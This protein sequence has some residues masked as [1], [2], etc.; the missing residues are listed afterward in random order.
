MAEETWRVVADG[1]EISSIGNVKA[2]DK[3]HGLR[4]PY[5]PSASRNGYVSF[6]HNKKRY[7]LARE[8]LT[9]F[10]GPAPVGTTVD[11][12]NGIRNDNRVCNLRW[13]TRSEQRLNQVGRR[14]RNDRDP[15]A[16]QDNLP[17]EDWVQVGRYNVS[18]MGRAQVMRSHG[19]AWGHVFTPKPSSKNVYAEIGR[20]NAFHR[21]V[22][23]A[24]LGP[25]PDK[26]YTV[27]HIDRDPT[28][29]ALDNLRWANKHTQSLNQQP[30]RPL[31]AL[32]KRVEVFDTKCNKWITFNSF[33]EAARDLE[34]AFPGKTFSSAGVGLTAR[35]LGTYHGVRL[36]LPG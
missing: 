10:V 11:H 25:P 22:A 20:G 15:D 12:I 7:Y 26:T 6:Q 23:L 3:V 8:I 32:S 5:K 1:L 2:L 9:A 16:N 33:T 29:N 35:R 30:G 21:V 18:N 14:N 36:R 27:D 34:E 24:F 28:N 31:K 17:G 13:A 19:N 4:G